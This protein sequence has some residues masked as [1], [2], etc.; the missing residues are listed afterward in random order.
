MHHHPLRLVHHQHVGVLIENRKRYIFRLHGRFHSLRNLKK[1]L[2]VHTQPVVCL[3]GQLI[4]HDLPLFDALLN[5]RTGKRRNCSAQPL[6]KPLLI[7]PHPN[8][9][10]EPLHMPPKIL[11]Q[12]FTRSVRRM[13][14]FRHSLVRNIELPSQLC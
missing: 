14:L 5:I 9:I 2:I 1:H 11:S 10:A 8:L 4:H 12:L 13:P 7:L 3:A 6:V